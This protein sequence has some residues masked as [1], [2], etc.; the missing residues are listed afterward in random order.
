MG[1]A[2]AGAAR[3]VELGAPRF[4]EK[5]EGLERRTAPLSVRA[6]AVDQRGAV[7]H[8]ETVAERK[9]A[10]AERFAAGRE[11]PLPTFVFTATR[12]SFDRDGREAEC[13]EVVRARA[14]IDF[15]NI[16]REF[17]VKLMKRE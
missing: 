15:A 6:P 8:G 9:Q 5:S 12:R 7:L 11:L 17:L 13:G 14:H 4:P 2:A 16:A 1:R 10:G 3:R